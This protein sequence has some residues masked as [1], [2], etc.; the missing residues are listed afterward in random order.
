MPLTRK[1][2]AKGK[3]RSKP[4]GKRGTSMARKADKYLLY[5]QAVQ[6]PESEIDFVSS[7]FRRL[8][9]RPA[10]RL[11]EDFCGTASVCCEWVRRHGDN[12][13]VGVD[14]NPVVLEW[15]RHNRLPELTPA[16]ARRVFL[17]NN[18]VLKAR[19]APA[20]IALAMNFSYWVFRERGLM[21]RYFRRVHSG[22]AR[23]GV[24][25]LDAYGGSEACSEQEESRKEKGFT[26]IWDQ[27]KYNPITGEMWCHIHFQF[28]DRSMM[29]RA[30]S[31]Y[32]RLWTLPELREI[33]QE[34]GFTSSVYWE[35]TDSR[36][37]EG[38]GYYRRTERGDADLSWIAYIVAEKS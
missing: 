11:R 35:N 17:V 30:F 16:Q 34:A 8:R 10:R 26:Y 4:N 14:L 3:T 37:G 38:N 31:Y 12:T 5:E 25:F 7:T 36:T 24:F 23:D 27:A 19:P 22:L 6:C 28:P 9:G 32:W 33:L 18:D 29:R 15:S 21:R 13:A 1:R 2:M 20:D